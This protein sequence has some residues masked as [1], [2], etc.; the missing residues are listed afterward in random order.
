MDVPSFF[1]VEPHEISR[2]VYRPASVR[3][4]LRFAISRSSESKI[5]VTM[6]TR[7]SVLVSAAFRKFWGDLWGC[8]KTL[9]FFRYNLP[10][11]KDKFVATRTASL[12]I[13]GRERGLLGTSE[14][15]Q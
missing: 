13:R 2:D 5:P 10:H 6:N 8:V 11:S 12:T 7:P 3:N 15:D 14:L 1:R 4:E 9:T